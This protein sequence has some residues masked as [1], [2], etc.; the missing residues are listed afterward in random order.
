MKNRQVQSVKT[1][2]PSGGRAVVGLFAGVGGIELGLQRAGF[3]ASLLCESDPA[4]QA[5]LKSRFPQIPLADDVRELDELPSDTFLLAGGF[6]CQDLSQAGPTRGIGGARSSLVTNVFRLLERFSVPWV[7]LENVPFMLRLNQGAAM[8]FI[9]DELERLGYKWAYRIV[10]TRAFGIPQRRE[11][12]FLLA[13]SVADPA[14]SLFQEDAGEMI[15]KN[16]EG[17]ACGFYWTEGTRGLGWAV[18][19]V[20]TLKGGSTVGIPSPPAIWLPD[21]SIVTPDIRD[22]ERLQGLDVDWT[23]PA[24]EVTR[25]SFRWKLVGNA[26]TVDVADWVGKCVLGEP[27]QDRPVGPPVRSLGSWPRAAFGS[28]EE[29][30]FEV[31]VSTWPVRRSPRCLTEYLEFETRPLSHRAAG[32]F[33]KRLKASTLKCYP[34]EFLNALERHMVSVAGADLLREYA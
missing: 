7:L 26:V 8:R 3:H 31:P 11:R 12:V 27:G 2:K 1:R 19:A 28:R 25:S 9:T 6:P 5:V 33:L 34:T 13:S 17:R 18:D 14:V 32:G 16:H 21:G 20:P 30:R 15:T 29:G 22:A 4:A 23:K 10:D 24:E